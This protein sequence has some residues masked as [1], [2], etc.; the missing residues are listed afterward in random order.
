MYSL[1]NIIDTV[2]SVFKIANTDYVN[3]GYKNIFYTSKD[4]LEQGRLLEYPDDTIFYKIV[5]QDNKIVLVD[6]SSIVGDIY[7]KPYQDIEVHE[8]SIVQFVYGEELLTGVINAILTEQKTN[9]TIYK[10]D[11]KNR[12]VFISGCSIVSVKK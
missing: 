1:K 7:F 2:L 4:V 9:V 5:N 6:R 12:F 10:V 11:L 8:N 3:E